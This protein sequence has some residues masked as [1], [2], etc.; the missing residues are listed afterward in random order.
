MSPYTRAHARST[1]RGGH[2]VARAIVLV[3]D[4]AALLI[5]LWITLWLL[6]ANQGNSLVSFVHDAADWL[7]GW[8][9]DLFTFDRAW[10]QVVVGYGLAALVYGCVGHAVAGRL[11]RR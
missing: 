4:A 3:A 2:P 8:S 11:T 1:A 9:Y 5:L 6:D 7:A 10:V